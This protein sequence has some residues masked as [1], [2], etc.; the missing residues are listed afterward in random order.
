MSVILKAVVDF[1][2][3]ATPVPEGRTSWLVS[4]GKLGNVMVVT[5]KEWSPWV[6][7]SIVKVLFT[8]SYATDPDRVV[9]AA[10]LERVACQVILATPEK[11]SSK[12]IVIIPRALSILAVRAGAD[13][14]SKQ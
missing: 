12:P 1:A 7:R 10:V 8:S 6:V 9:E 2:S 14:I 11:S 4:V 13:P 5:P 3:N